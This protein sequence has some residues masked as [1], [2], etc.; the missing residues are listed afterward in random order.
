MAADELL[1]WCLASPCVFFSFAEAWNEKK[2][3]GIEKRG[4]NNTVHSVN[5][6]HVK[7]SL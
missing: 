7:V 4:V 5:V 1:V 3:E 6:Q 2:K